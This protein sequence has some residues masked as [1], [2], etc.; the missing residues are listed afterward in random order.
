MKGYENGAETYDFQNL[1]LKFRCSLRL[2]KGL[3][4]QAY[5]NSSSVFKGEADVF[6]CVIKFETVF[7]TSN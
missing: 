7:I 2:K 6:G 1:F 4:F 3:Y 5:E